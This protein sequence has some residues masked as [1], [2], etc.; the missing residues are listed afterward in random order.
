MAAWSNIS[1]CNRSLSLFGECYIEYTEWSWNTL[2]LSSIVYEFFKQ[3]NNFNPFVL[4]LSLDSTNSL[5]FTHS[6]IPLPCAECDNSLSF[7]GPSSIPLCYTFFL[8]PFSTHYFLTSLCNLFLGLPLS[9]A[10]SKFICN[11]FLRILFPSILCTC[12]NHCKPFNSLSFTYYKMCIHE[13]A[14]YAF[15]TK[16]TLHSVHCG[17]WHCLR[18]S[19][20]SHAYSFPHS[21]TTL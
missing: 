12:P 15:G 4:L 9:P 11:T 1:P 5:S 16:S 6:F 10:V 20:F 14:R 21:I 2:Y 7:S 19:V 8:P 13:C 18:S 17:Y 3:K